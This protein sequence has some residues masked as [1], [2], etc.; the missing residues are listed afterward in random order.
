MERSR[1]GKGWLA[2]REVSIKSTRTAGNDTLKGAHKDGLT[3]SSDRSKV[4][5]G[6]HFFAKV[7]SPSE[8]WRNNW[9]GNTPRDSPK[10][11]KYRWVNTR[12][13][14]PS[15]VLTPYPSY[16]LRMLIVK[17]LGASRD[18]FPPFVSP[19]FSVPLCFSNLRRTTFVWRV[20]PFWGRGVGGVFSPYLFS[21]EAIN[22][23]IYNSVCL[24]SSFSPE[25]PIET[26][27]YICMLP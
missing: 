11:L 26:F 6:K 19:S 3:G 17:Q 4:R 15:L 22:I 8:S 10:A 13:G 5:G 14:L 24:S 23:V 1:G 21:T 7:M 9:G 27:A 18:F 20:F 25:K 12:T 16:T 2:G